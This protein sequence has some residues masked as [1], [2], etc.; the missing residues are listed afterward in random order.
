MCFCEDGNELM[1]SICGKEF[2]VRSLS[3]STGFISVLL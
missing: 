3:L 1:V 2:T